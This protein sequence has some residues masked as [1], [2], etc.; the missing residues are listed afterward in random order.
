MSWK[1]QQKYV[2]QKT[3]TT[4]TPITS[5]SGV[6]HCVQT[7]SYWGQHESL[8]T[9][10]LVYPGAHSSATGHN[11]SSSES[12]LH[13][14]NQLVKIVISIT[15]LLCRFQLCRHSFMI[16]SIAWALPLAIEFEKME[17]KLIIFVRW[18][19]QNDLQYSNVGYKNYPNKQTRQYRFHPFRKPHKSSKT[20]AQW[21]PTYLGLENPTK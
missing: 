20:L 21:F 1:L 3:L 15:Q 10:R 6:T 16:L 9:S 17:K 18:L 14:V 19:T 2:Q 4:L 7:H 8:S 13:T 12:S 11:L 5:L